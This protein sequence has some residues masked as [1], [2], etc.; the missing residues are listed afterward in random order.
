M[1]DASLKLN[2]PIY[3]LVNHGQTM[4]KLGVMYE[5][6]DLPLT[7]PRIGGACYHSGG[8]LPRKNH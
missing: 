1:G 3:F 7:G 6:M 5:H 2:Y 8:N 4:V